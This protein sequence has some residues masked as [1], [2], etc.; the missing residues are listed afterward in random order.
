MV[1]KKISLLCFW[2]QKQLGCFP[3][4]TNVDPHGLDGFFGVLSKAL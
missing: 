2:R 4:F 3:V 1:E